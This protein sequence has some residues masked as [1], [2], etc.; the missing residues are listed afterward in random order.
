MKTFRCNFGYGVIATMTAPDEYPGAG[1]SYQK[2]EWTC[3]LTRKIVKR[4]YPRYKQWV[5]DCTQNLADD[6]GIAI[7]YV[8]L[9][10]DNGLEAW[11]FE[12]GKSEPSICTPDRKQP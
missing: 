11:R 12:P 8:F 10:P 4:I 9:L 3:D 5:F 6:W 2:T 1:Q 7:V